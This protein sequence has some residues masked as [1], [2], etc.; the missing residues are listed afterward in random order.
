VGFHAP[1]ETA[2]LLA[3]SINHSREGQDALRELK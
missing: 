3:L 2:R 1:Q